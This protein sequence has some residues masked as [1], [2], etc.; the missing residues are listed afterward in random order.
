[1]IAA[2][3]KEMDLRKDY[4]G[5]AGI[6]TIYLGG[7][8][9]SILE[10]PLLERIF[11]KLHALFSIEG[12][13]EITLEANPDDL[14]DEKLLLFRSLGINRLSIGIQTFDDRLLHYLNRV[15]NREQALLSY[16]RARAAGFVNISIDLMY[17]IPGQTPGGWL[18]DLEQTLALAPAHISAYC[19]TIEERTAFGHWLKTKTLQPVPDEEAADYLQVLMDT[20]TAHGYEHYEISNFAKPGYQSRHNSSYWKQVPYLGIGPGAHSYNG[21]SRQANIS[22]NYRY[23]QAILAGEIP[24]QVEPLTREEKINEYILTRLRTSWGV[25]TRQLKQD[26]NFDLIGKNTELLARLTANGFVS[27]T[28]G[29]IKLT[30]PGKLLADKIAADLFDI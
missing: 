18:N 2:M 15:H 21:N 8:T 7:G 24:A 6:D 4:L 26:F 17:A 25:D 19:L 16:E 9:P 3:E 20:L 1:M 14:T 28:D 13:A 29:I 22:N 27:I 10:A 5:M 30:P 11:N 23:V 12:F